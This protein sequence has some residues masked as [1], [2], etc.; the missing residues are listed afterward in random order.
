MRLEKETDRLN[1]QLVG[2]EKK[3]SNQDFLDKAPKEIVKQEKEKMNS[4]NEK[5]NKIK[6]NLQRLN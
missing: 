3:L 6:L 1:K 2:L 5:L 4:F